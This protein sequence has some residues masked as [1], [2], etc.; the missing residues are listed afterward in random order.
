MSGYFND[1]EALANAALECDGRGVGVYVTLNPVRPE[2]LAR[3]AN[4]IK[5]Y[6]KQTTTSDDILRLRYLL[7][8]VDAVRPSG[9]CATQAECDSALRVAVRILLWL[10]AQGWPEPAIS[11]S[12]NG[13]HLVYAV[14]L[15]NDEPSRQL[16]LRC[17]Q[18]LAFDFSDDQAIVDE[19]TA[20]P[21]QLWRLP[22]TLNAKGDDLP[23]RPHRVTKLLQCPDTLCAVTRAQLDQLAA[24]IP[25]ASPMPSGAR[26]THAFDLEQWITQY[27]LPIAH[28]GPWKGGRKWVLA[29]CPWNPTHI[30]RAAYIVQSSSGAIAAGCHHNACRGNNWQALRALVEPGHA[31]DSEHTEHSEL[32]GPGQWEPPIPFP[33]IALPP[34]PTEALPGWLAD[35]VD[36]LATET[37]TPPDLAALVALSVIAA[38]CAGVVQVEAESGWIEPVNIFA[39]VAMD[40]G[41]RK[42]P[43]FSAA[44]APLVRTEKFT[45]QERAGQ[46]IAA[47]SQY[48]LAQQRVK[49]AQAALR[50]APPA[51]HA[52]R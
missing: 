36:A 18:A 17:L 5:P 51:E 1:P 46:I 44:V 11:D 33:N 40:P 16:L 50:K 26:L 39:V 9:I 35:Y 24:R 34:F 45:N 37:Q 41:N 42:S 4:R 20:K 29:R 7:I 23:E 15:P 32:L 13:A 49:E 31:P 25:V 38:S 30:D 19:S 48:D 10:R 43:V 8:D 27:D 2:L 47:Q 21:A 14:D 52:Q 6:A 28:T 12:G 22:G 3:S